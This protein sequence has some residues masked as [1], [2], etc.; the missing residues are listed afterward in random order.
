MEKH[1]STVQSLSISQGVAKEALSCVSDSL[2]CC[3]IG[4]RMGSGDRTHT[5]VITVVYYMGVVVMM[6]HGSNFVYMYVDWER[7]RVSWIAQ[8]LLRVAKCSL[9]LWF[10]VTS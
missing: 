2:Q 7:V 1:S 3:N 10:I 5:S 6:R 9:P 4:I 8:L